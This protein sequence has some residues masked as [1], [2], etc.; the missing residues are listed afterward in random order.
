MMKS[1][2]LKHS[3]IRQL[4]RRSTM[5]FGQRTSSPH[6]PIKTAPARPTMVPETTTKAVKPNDQAQ[7]TRRNI[8]Q[9]QGQ[10][11]ALSP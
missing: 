11:P 8:K 4:T 9:Y 5:R 1:P 10:M 3:P 7:Q 2:S 6:K